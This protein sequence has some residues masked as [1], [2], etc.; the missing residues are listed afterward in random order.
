MP[1]SNK[2]PEELISVNNLQTH[3]FTSQGTLKAVD[4]VS[5]KIHKGETVGLIGE[6][7]SGKTTV[8]F[9]ILRLIPH[10]IET[11]SGVRSVPLLRR[12]GT[13]IFKLPP[14]VVSTGEII[15]GEVW[16]KGKD[17]MS[18]PEEEMHEIRGREISMVF[19]N[20]ISSMHPLMT[21]GYQVGEPKETHEKFEW[22]KI[23]KIVFEYLGRVQI[24]DAKKRYYHD[25]HMFSVGE[26]QR[27]MIAMALMCN[28]SLLIAD[29]PTSSLDV[30]V[31]RQVLELL[32]RMKKEFNLSMLLMTHN[33]G[34]IAEMSDSV[35][36]MYAGR[37]LEYGDVFTIFKDPKHPYTKELLANTP[38]IDKKIELKG[39]LGHP[40]DPYD[41]PKGCE[42][43]PRCKHSDQG[44]N[45]QKPSLVEIKPG[46][47]VAC[48]KSS[49]I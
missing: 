45:Q 11:R 14:K 42:Y 38:R 12:T 44:C 49:A 5:F 20:P 47:F 43:L 10:I 33:L 2:R 36:V 17:L 25:P 39:M 18:L 24:A 6:T 31:Q 28:P 19:Q 21:I 48:L 37:F 41:L 35:G 8:A 7:G 32:K 46:H 9:S 23:R 34:I 4:G 30:L 26:G 22:S 40:L 1:I 13:K 29:E 3:F 16:F 15:D 27:I